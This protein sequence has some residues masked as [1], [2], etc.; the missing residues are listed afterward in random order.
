MDVYVLRKELKFNICRLET[1][2]LANTDVEGLDLKIKNKIT[3]QLIYSSP[4]WANHL[5]E[6]QMT[7]DNASTITSLVDVVDQFFTEHLLHWFEVLSLLKAADIASVML[8]ICA[9]WL[10]VRKVK[11]MFITSVFIRRLG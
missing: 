5:A 6:I 8:L 4:Y 9:R 1:S 2:Y 3:P 10:R 11:L 7:N